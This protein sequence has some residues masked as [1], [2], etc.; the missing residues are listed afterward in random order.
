MKNIYIYIINTSYN[1]LKIISL[2]IH[3]KINNLLDYKIIIRC[4]YIKRI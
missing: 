1:E 4:K 3:Y 2:C